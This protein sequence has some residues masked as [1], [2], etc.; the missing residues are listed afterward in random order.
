MFT[1]IVEELGTVAAVEDQGDAVRL[2]LAA[3][4]VLEVAALVWANSVLVTQDA[5]EAVQGKAS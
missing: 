5:L 3:T 1:G 4:T 2:T